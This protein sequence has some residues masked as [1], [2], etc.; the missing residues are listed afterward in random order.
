M[1]VFFLLTGID[2]LLKDPQ[3]N[4][5]CALF[6]CELERVRQEVENDLKVSLLISPHLSDDVHVFRRLDI[7]N[8]LKFLEVGLGLD[9]IESLVNYHP[10]VEEFLCQFEC[11]ILKFDKIHHVV[12]QTLR[13]ILGVF[14]LKQQLLRSITSLVDVVIQLFPCLL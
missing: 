10:Q 7:A 13:H 9:N 8:K 2:L 4:S 3:R 11:S 14:L 5:N 12:D 1:L 6:L